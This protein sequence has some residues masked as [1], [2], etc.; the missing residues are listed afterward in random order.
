[1]DRG[2]NNVINNFSANIVIY[3]GSSSPSGRRN[4]IYNYWGVSNPVIGQFYP[5]NL[6]EY[7][8]SPYDPVI[9]TISSFEEDSLKQIFQNAFELEM[10]SEYEAALVLYKYLA[11]NYPDELYG[12]ASLDRI[13]ECAIS[14]E[15]DYFEMQEYFVEL[16]IAFENELFSKLAYSNSISLKVSGEEFEDAIEDYYGLFPSCITYS[17]SANLAINICTTYMLA[18]L[19]NGG[20]GSYTGAV[21]SSFVPKDIQDYHNKV[22]S[23]LSGDWIFDSNSS[24]YLTPASYSLKPNF[25]NP[26]NPSTTISYTLPASGEISLTVY[27]ISGR[28]IARLYDGYHSAGSY[29]AV[30]DG[31]NLPSGVYF[32]RLTARDFTQTQKMLLLK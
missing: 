1:M 15:M 16:S 26:F 8:Y 22:E 5:N 29:K 10:S 17:D 31:G 14:G 19:A 24:T 11:E 12:L 9:N 21:T 6:V 32:A 30:F 25:P 18:D 20:F 4:I 23:L 27:D 7:I 13:K 2:H 28:E 3:D